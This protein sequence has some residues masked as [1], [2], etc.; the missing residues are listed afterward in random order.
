MKYGGQDMW[1]H[2]T[3]FA[4]LRSELG[5]FAG[6]DSLPGFNSLKKDDQKEVKTQL[7]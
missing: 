7:P 1:H 5:Y 4:K 3:C 2:L 6:G